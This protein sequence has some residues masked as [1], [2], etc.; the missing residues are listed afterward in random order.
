MI[1]RRSDGVFANDLYTTPD[2][3][4]FPAVVTV[5][6]TAEHGGLTASLALPEALPGLNIGQLLA[7]AFGPLAG[8]HAGIG[9]APRGEA[10]A[11][12]RGR[13]FA[14]LLADL[15]AFRGE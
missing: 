8:G 10:V 4:P 5:N 2:G 11:L 15:L 7:A 14:R 13:A 3:A 12:E 1:L 6:E 9:G